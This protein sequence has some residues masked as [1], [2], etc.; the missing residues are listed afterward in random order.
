MIRTF[1]WRDIPTLQRYRDRGL[2]LS[3]ILVTTRGRL[4]LPGALLSSFSSASGIFT[5]VFKEDRRSGLVLIGQ[6]IHSNGL[7]YAR[8][9]FLAPDESIDH[10][11]MVKVLEHLAQQTGKHGAHQ[12]LAEIDDA[13]EGFEA[14]RKAG[15]TIYS[16][17]RIWKFSKP[18][19]DHKSETRWEKPSAV[20]MFAINALHQNLVPGLVQQ[21]EPIDQ[22]KFQGLIS[23][24]NGEL[25][26]YVEFHYGSRGIWA[27]PFIHPDIED[28]EPFLRSMLQKIHD[29]RSRRIFVCVRSYQSWLEH[30]LEELGG[31]PGSLQA[32]MVKRIAVRHKVSSPV[33]LPQIEG[34]PDISAPISQIQPDSHNN[35]SHH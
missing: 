13:S 26:G 31:K 24:S 23:R 14:L 33:P 32:V 30:A 4:V 15:F 17:Q 22:N 9:S 7:P 10:P 16:R 12:L 27:Q 28:P 6:A 29:L 20:D 2:Y 19:R 11:G 8:V 5:S 25:N 34:Q 3:S 1:D 18:A 21:L 35:G